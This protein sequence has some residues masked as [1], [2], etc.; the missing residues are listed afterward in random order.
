MNQSNTKNSNSPLLSLVVIVI[1]FTSLSFSP[2]EKGISDMSSE[3][4]PDE[5]ASR[6]SQFSNVK[7]PTQSQNP[8][9]VCKYKSTETGLIQFRGRDYK[10][11]FTRTANKCFKVRQALFE[12]KKKR[13]LSEDYGSL[14]IE[15][16]TNDI[17]CS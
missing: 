1:A 7:S 10:Q 4:L 5:V 12:Q 17:T 3:A 9:V 13:A 8:W 2:Q 15:L 6:A 14:Y 16:C 11:A